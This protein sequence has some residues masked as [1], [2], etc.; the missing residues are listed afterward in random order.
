MSSSEGEVSESLELGQRSSEY[1][2]RDSAMLRCQYYLRTTQFY[3]VSSQHEGIGSRKDKNWFLVREPGS[4]E[5]LLLSMLPNS[6]NCPF[7]FTKQTARTL[8]DMFNILKHPYLQPIQGVGFDSEQG[9]TVL[10]QPFSSKGS[11]K[12]LICKASPL[13]R[14]PR[15]Y[16]RSGKP[17]NGGVVATYGR[18]ILEALLFLKSKGFP[19][20]TNVHTGNV[21]ICSQVCRVSGHELSLLG[22][23]S[24]LKKAIDKKDKS[25][26]ETVLF[27]HIIFEMATGRSLD[28]DASS[29]ESSDYEQCRANPE[30]IQVL[31]FIFN[32]ESGR[33]PSIEEVSYLPFFANVALMELQLFDPSLVVISSSAKSLL[34]TVRKNRPHSAK[35]RKSSRQLEDR[36]TDVSPKTSSQAPPRNSTSRQSSTRHSTTSLVHTSPPPQTTPQTAPQTAV[37]TTPS[38]RKALLDQIHTGV[39]LKKTTTHDRSGPRV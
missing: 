7:P 30:I 4:Q 18:Q 23:P 5:D 38:G 8:R 3:N 2:N 36:G 27:G 17:L 28:S 6:T 21:I 29:L 24:K 14:I 11:L 15:K 33:F 20:C 10:V 25:A 31:K 9:Y 35:R 34:K 16:S 22:Y 13:D 1:Q 26:W 12:D 39:K 32:N 19:P 37:H